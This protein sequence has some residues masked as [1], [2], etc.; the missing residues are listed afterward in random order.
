V[1]MIDDPER[2]PRASLHEE[3]RADQ[4]GFVAQ[5]NAML[6]G[7]A[8]VELGAG[9]ARKTDPI[10]PAVGVIVHRKVGDRVTAGD[11]MF[12]VYANDEQRLARARDLLLQ[13]PVYRDREQEP[14]PTFYDTIVASPSA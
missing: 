7:Q 3:V 10:D 2:L 1:S 9:R 11:V 5:V 14:L 8:V 6:V 12:T 4:T 13:A